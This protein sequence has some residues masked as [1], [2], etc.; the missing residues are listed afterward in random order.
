MDNA[1]ESG[2][3]DIQADQE[4]IVFSASP[5]SF[6]ATKE[7]GIL[8]FAICKDHQVIGFF[9]L[10]TLFG[11]RNDFCPANSL[12]LCTL[13]ID[14]RLQGKGVGT[15][16]VIKTIEYAKAHFEQCEYL[17]LTV[18]CQNPAAY[19]CYLK[20]GFEDTQTLF[21]GGPAGPQHIMRSSI[22]PV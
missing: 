12:G 21:L 18:N 5:E 1:L 7:A 3:L 14:K 2:I 4:Q 6:L 15:Q 17:Y 8:P 13:L 22:N 16:S 9:K 19:H 20:S 10:D 11:Q